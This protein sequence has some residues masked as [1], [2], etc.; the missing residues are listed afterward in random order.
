[1]SFY[2]YDWQEVDINWEALDLNWEEVGFIEKDILPFVAI[3]GGIPKYDLE[4]LDKLSRKKKIKLIRIACRIEG[5][6]F[7]ESKFKNEKDIKI[8]TEHLDSVINKIIKVNV[9]NIS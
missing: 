4:E 6:D 2:Y 3:V 5:K 7:I 1:M 8:T 9:Q